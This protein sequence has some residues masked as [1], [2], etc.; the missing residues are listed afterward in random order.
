VTID[1]VGIF[2]YEYSLQVGGK[3]FEKFRDQ[4]KKALQ[5]HTSQI[6]HIQVNFIF[7][8]RFGM[9]VWAKMSTEFVWV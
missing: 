6:I 8:L 1:P 5:V 7:I 2:T 9:F 3:A 4:Q